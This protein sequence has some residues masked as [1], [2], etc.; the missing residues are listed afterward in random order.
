MT[1]D[2]ILIGFMDGRSETIVLDEEFNP[3]NDELRFTTKSTG[4]RKTFRLANLCSV[5]VRQ[6]PSYLNIPSKPEWVEEV[7]TV[8]GKHYH[9]VPLEGTSFDRGFFAYSLEKM[10]TIYRFVFFTSQ[11]VKSRRQERPV[12]NILLEQGLVTEAHIGEALK[13]QHELRL[14]P[15][16]E[17]ISAHANIPKEIIE[18][19]IQEKY[20]KDGGSYKL[21]TGEILIEAGLLTKEQVETA[22]ATQSLGKRKWIGELLIDLGYITEAQLL[23]ALA[24]KFRRK[25]V[26]LSKLTPDKKAL[27]AIPRDIAY[28]FNIFPVEDQG[29]QLVVATAQPADHTI[30]DALQF[31][32]HRHIGIVIA[33]SKQI[34]EALEA[35][36]PGDHDQITG[37][38]GQLTEDK[39]IHEEEI[40]DVVSESDSQIISLVNRILDDAYGKRASDI[41]FEPGMAR[42]PF[43]VRFRVDGVCNLAYTIPEIYKRAILSRIKIM[44][45]LDIAEHRK[46]Q[47]GKF[48]MRIHGE[49]VEFRVE[50]TPTADG[51]EDAVLRLLAQTRP[52]PIED[53]GL[54]AY[55]LNAFREMITKP[56]G[57]VLCVGPTGSGKTT[58][59]HSALG[60]INKPEI[61]IWTAE[62]P[63]EIRQHGLRQVQINT[64]IGYT[65]SE[66]LRSFLRSDPDVIM[67]GEMRDAETAKI[68]LEASL[69]GHLVFSTL[70]TN[71][72]AETV[73]RIIEMGI[74]FYNF[75]D[76]LLGIVAQR[77]ARRLCDRCKQPYHP[78]RE[79]YDELMNYYDPKWGGV[80]KLPDFSPGVSLW[81]REGCSVCNGSGY[82][83]RIAIHEIILAKE[84]VKKAIRHN[85]DVEE[86]KNVALR[87]GMRTLRMD[88]VM[89]IMQGVTDYEQVKRVCL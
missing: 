10:H 12:G 76:A 29:T 19:V 33:T 35:H 5:M 13:A 15:I 75:A 17:I 36:Y 25:F 65:F 21:K 2:D 24:Q 55:N 20:R 9:V 32:T 71:S 77:L 16:G 46:P 72:A 66:A 31:Y 49:K 11:G 87:E 61:K 1:Q 54:S 8:T 6:K 79:E 78:D 68:A 56:Q 22:M 57:I 81:K 39:L 7:I 53:L 40:D 42:T 59:L 70:H 67:I 27:A 4:M 63:V 86:L 50:V 85:V 41:H 60:Y 84:D 64:K 51:N 38:I 43:E 80:D 88:G 48:M 69:T 34:A 45:N 89:K 30:E 3:A 62:N 82:Y 58:T 52:L 74:P 83:D 47:S 44:S 28:Q 18:Q 37:L 14:K 23:A 26:D 73:V